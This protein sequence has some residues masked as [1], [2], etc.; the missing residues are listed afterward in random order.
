[1]LQVSST[2]FQND[3]LNNTNEEFPSLV[4][5]LNSDDTEVI[6]Q[7]TQTQDKAKEQG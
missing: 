6:S 7:P 1:M 4:F 2:Q 5:C 3:S